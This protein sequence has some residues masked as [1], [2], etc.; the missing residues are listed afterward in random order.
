MAF[1]DEQAARESRRVSGMTLIELVT[2]IVLTGILSSVFAGLLRIPMDGYSAVSRRSELV[3]N[4]DLAVGRM[5]RDLRAALPNSIRVSASGTVMEMIGTSDGGRYRASGGINS[6][7]NH[8]AASDY[9][10]FSGD[11]SFNLLG[12]FQSLPISYGAAMGSGTRIAVYPTSVSVWNEAAAGSNPGVIT[13]ATT[14][15]TISDDGD[16]DQIFLSASHQFSAESPTKRLYVVDTPITYFC[17]LSTK[18]LSRVDG[19][20]IVAT[21]PTLLSAAP[22]SGGDAH[23]A[24][25]QVASCAF[26]YV[27]GSGTRTGLVTI[28]IALSSGGE[29]VRLLHQVEVKNAP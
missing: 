15:V 12:R 10:S 13:P 24:A 3:A 11:T 21:Q 26:S 25:E 14:T 20:S 1:V 27:P 4:A 7:H 29:S 6:G 5:A 23:R 8:T 19:Y 16:E 17:D 2:V 9:I 28:E 22:L 18:I